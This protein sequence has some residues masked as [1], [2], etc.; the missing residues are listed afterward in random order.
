MHDT[1]GYDKSLFMNS[2]CEAVE[3]SIKFAR[4]WAYEVKKVPSN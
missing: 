4:R 2:G 1:F 3:S